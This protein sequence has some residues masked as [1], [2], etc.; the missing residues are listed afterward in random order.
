MRILN[1]RVQLL[2]LC[3][4]AILGVGNA[5]AQECVTAPPGMV[6]WWPGEGTGQDIIGGNDGTLNGGMGTVPGLVD[7]AFSFDGIDDF[8]SL[9]TLGFGPAFTI[10]AWINTSSGGSYHGILSVCDDPN[11]DCTGGD[12]KVM[13]FR[14]NP[15][16]AILAGFSF[17]DFSVRRILATTPAGVVV[18]GSWYHVATTIDSGTDEIQI[19]L[20]GVPQALSLSIIG[21]GSGSFN[22]PPYIGGRHSVFGGVLQN[23][24]HGQIDEVEFFDRVLLPTEIA[25]LH[26]AGSA[27]KCKGACCNDGPGTESACVMET[28]RTPCESEGGLYLGDGTECADV[29]DCTVLL[30]TM[31]SMS[32]T[33]TPRG[34]LL[35]WTTVTEVDT[36]GFRLLR[37]TPGSREKALKVIAPM[38]PA[39]GTG[40]TGATYQFLDNTYRP[41]SAAQYYVEDI[42]IFGKV[43]RHGP[44]VVERIAPTRAATEHRVVPTR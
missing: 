26:A 22:G 32:A 12:Y 5:V 18:P 19:Y 23:P 34:V 2:A 37:I 10:D 20:D 35:A 7:E 8:V 14:V 42:D 17:S 27:G 6:S 36:V 38:I 41:G 43:T 15:D 29:I 21:S 39:S 11:S 16:G 24:F 4:V 40:L 30:V 1:R 31:E 9:P 33:A 44:I 13:V 28:S 25:A 3:A